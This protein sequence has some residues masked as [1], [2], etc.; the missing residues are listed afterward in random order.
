MKLHKPRERGYWHTDDRAALALG[1]SGQ[2]PP[3]AI[4]CFT[5]DACNEPRVIALQ[6]DSLRLLAVGEFGP[7]RG[8]RIKWTGSSHRWGV[9]DDGYRVVL[10][11]AHGGGHDAY[12]YRHH[13]ADTIRRMAETLDSGA[14]W[15]FCMVL[16]HSYSGGRDQE[17]KRW[18]L[19]AAENRIK[20]N[21]RY[22][23]PRIT[24]LP[25]VGS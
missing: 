1:D 5:M 22:K 8:E 6:T 17:A 2:E 24:I 3:R 13:Q 14:L 18:H 23:R 16:R 19:R 4:D 10:L 25:R 11:V 7:A 21:R 20:V 15:D 9:Y 12:A